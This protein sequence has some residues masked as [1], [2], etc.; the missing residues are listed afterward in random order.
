MKTFFPLAL[1]LLSSCAT[2]PKHVPKFERSEWR[3]GQ[4]ENKNCLDTR[5]EVLKARSL[6]PVTMNKRGCRVMTGKW[7]DYYYPKSYHKA[8]ELHIDHLVPLRHAHGA[9]GHA[10]SLSTKQAFANDPENLVITGKRYNQIKGAQTVATWLPSEHP[11]ACRYLRD[12]IKIK[13]KYKLPL[14]REERDA[15]IGCGN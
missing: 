2:F 3:Y 5:A 13:K 14:P 10:W 4:D 1:W 8:S 7:N 12:W 15:V 11:Y 9:G 6:V